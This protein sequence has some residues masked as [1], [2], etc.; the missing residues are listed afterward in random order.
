MSPC[1]RS[2]LPPEE[3]RRRAA[4]KA[5][6]TREARAYEDKQRR[7]KAR[8]E[9]I[10]AKRAQEGGEDDSE[11]DDAD[12]TGLIDHEAPAALQEDAHAK[13]LFPDTLNRKR[14]RNDAHPVSYFPNRF[15]LGFVHNL[16]LKEDSSPHVQNHSMWAYE[17]CISAVKVVLIPQVIC[18]A[19]HLPRLRSVQ[20]YLYVFV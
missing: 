2:V 5:I 19:C 18:P 7:V 14:K 10:Q 4:R 16:F 12:E 1:L 11:G 9:R 6:Q 8:L 20:L 13:L 15:S 17:Y 3:R